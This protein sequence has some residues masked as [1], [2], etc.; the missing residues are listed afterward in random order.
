MERNGE[1]GS[2]IFLIIIFCALFGALS[3]AV[4][5]SMRAGGDF[6]SKEKLDLQ[7]SEILTF[8]NSMQTGIKAVMVN[9]CTDTQISFE[10]PILSGYTNASAPADRSCNVFNVNGAGISYLPVNKTMLDPAFSSQPGYGSWL[11]TAEY[12][13]NSIGTGT[14]GSC[15]SANSDMLLILRYVTK[16]ICNQFISLA[17]YPQ[18]APA[19]IYAVPNLPFTGTYGTTVLASSQ[20]NGRLRG[21]MEYPGTHRDVFMVILP[22]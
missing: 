19:S 4:T 3:Y 9:G 21:C 20:M 17:N 12:C 16:D 8:G 5:Q 6:G 2:V 10:N 15:T 14:G 11:F 13:I 22:R 7:I 18:S 1:R